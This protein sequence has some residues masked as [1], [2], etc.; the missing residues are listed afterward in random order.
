MSVR[1]F[2]GLNIDFVS[3]KKCIEQWF[4]ERGFLVQSCATD[5]QHV[6][7]AAK[8]SLVRSA[9]GGAR[10]YNISIRWF[11]FKASVSLSVARR[12]L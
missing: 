11:V 7:Q 9:L 12:S 10:A 1:H 4:E 2:Q 5:N 8:E 3:L 6:V